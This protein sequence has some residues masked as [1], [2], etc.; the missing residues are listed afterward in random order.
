MDGWMD[1]WIVL[2]SAQYFFQLYGHIVMLL[3][4]NNKVY[5]QDV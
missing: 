5:A 4:D 1:G 2:S 3:M